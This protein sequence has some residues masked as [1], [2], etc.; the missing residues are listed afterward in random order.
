MFKPLEV[1]VARALFSFCL[2]LSN[3]RQHPARGRL[4]L[5]TG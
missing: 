5:G 4:H 1:A 2:L 3:I